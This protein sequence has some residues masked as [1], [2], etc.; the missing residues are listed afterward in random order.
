MYKRRELYERREAYERYDPHEKHGSPSVANRTGAASGRTP[1]RMVTDGAGKGIMGQNGN[2]KE[3]AMARVVV[4]GSLNMDLT[5]EAPRIPAGGETLTGGGFLTNPGG[6]G[7]NQAVAAAKLGADTCMVGAVG[8]D[9]FG[10]ELAAGLAAAGADCTGIARAEGAPT[11][12]AMII[13]TQGENRIILDPGANHV[14]R[15]PAVNAALDHLAQPGDVFVTQLECDHAT[16]FAAL[17]EAHVRGLYTVFNPAPAVPV[18][19]E[20]WPAVDLLC[21]N[22]TETQIITGVLPEDEATIAQAAAWFAEKRV[23]PVIVT[24]GGRGSV[25]LQGGAVTPIA[26]SA[27]TVVDT[28]AAGDTYLGALA[29]QLAAVAEKHAACGDAAERGAAARPSFSPAEIEAAARYASAAAALATTK[30]GAQ[31]SVPTAAEVAAFLA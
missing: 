1:E 9:A 30:L 21:L 14:L 7:A 15:T 23:D 25:L 11:G 17:A 31:Q 18:P 28:T 2:G 4:F 8:Q 27:V 12:V 13:R 5:I 26:P 6:K 16:T 29:A 24:L 22:E 10:D 3:G 19:D 20:V